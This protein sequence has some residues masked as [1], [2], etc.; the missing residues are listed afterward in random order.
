ME[1][2]PNNWTKTEIK[3]K[4][5]SINVYIQRVYVTWF[6]YFNLV[7]SLTIFFNITHTNSN[8][9]FYNI[10]TSPGDDDTE[11]IRLKWIIDLWAAL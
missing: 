4:V 2:P 3:V 10:L 7:S 1:V 9:C 5:K 6:K 8:K 11:K